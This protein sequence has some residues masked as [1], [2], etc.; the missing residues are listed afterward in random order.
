MMFPKKVFKNHIFFVFLQEVMHLFDQL[1]L[2][3]LKVTLNCIS[4][5]NFYL[6]DQQQFIYSYSTKYC[7]IL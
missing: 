2:F 1:F 7:K 5:K 6:Q 3:S 4:R